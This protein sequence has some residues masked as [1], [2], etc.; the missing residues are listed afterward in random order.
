MP[1]IQVMPNDLDLNGHANNARY[2]TLMDLMLVGYFVR[3]GV[4]NVSFGEGERPIAGVSIVT[5]RRWLKPL[6]KIRPA[7]PDRGK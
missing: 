3:V 7:L 4:A 5:C 6:P 1:Q 2:L